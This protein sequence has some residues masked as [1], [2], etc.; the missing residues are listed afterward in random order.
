METGNWKKETGNWKKETGRLKL[1][2]HGC[3]VLKSEI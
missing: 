1:D 3:M 2:G